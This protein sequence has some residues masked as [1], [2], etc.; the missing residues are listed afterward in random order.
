ML[1]ML[2]RRALVFARLKFML[3]RPGLDWV[4]TSLVLFSTNDF[5]WMGAVMT[6]SSRLRWLLVSL[7]RLWLPVIFIVGAKKVDFDSLAL[8]SKL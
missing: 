5:R 2:L 7:S 1:V 8:G 4:T 6:L 3:R